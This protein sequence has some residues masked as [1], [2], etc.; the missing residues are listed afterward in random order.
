MNGLIIINCK[1]SIFVILVGCLFIFVNTSNTFSES[2]SHLGA[3][4]NQTLIWPIIVIF[5]TILL[6]SLYYKNESG[7][8]PSFMM[9]FMYLI[10]ALSAS[11]SEAINGVFFNRY[12]EV[13]LNYIGVSHILYGLQHWR[14]ILG[15]L[16]KDVS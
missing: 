2:F 3:Y 15:A 9:G 10:P 5:L 6:L 16:G 14:E 1:L 11:I 4:R 7:Q 12:E 13:F 8:V